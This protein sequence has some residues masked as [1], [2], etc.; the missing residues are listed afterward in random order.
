MDSALTSLACCRE[1]LIWEMLC[2]RELW[3]ELTRKFLESYKKCERKSLPWRR[4]LQTW[5]PVGCFLQ[6]AR[7]TMMSCPLKSWVGWISNWT[8]SLTSLEQ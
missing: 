8:V 1:S 2:S 4:I 6:S 3:V 7:S 5:I